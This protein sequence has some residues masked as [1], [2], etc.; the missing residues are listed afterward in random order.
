LGEGLV[1]GLIKQIAEDYVKYNGFGVIGGQSVQQPG[2]AGAVPGLRVFLTELL[3]GGV[4]QI[5]HHEF[6][7]VDEGAKSERK[8][9]TG[10]LQML[11]EGCCQAEEPH[12]SREQASE[13]SGHGPD[14]NVFRLRILPDSGNI[15]AFSENVVFMSSKNVVIDKTSSGSF[16]RNGMISP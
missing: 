11:A 7:G 1:G 4:I 3:V 12:A 6:L 2:V 5:N 15:R 14:L 10:G 13:D 8:I 16:H 9:V